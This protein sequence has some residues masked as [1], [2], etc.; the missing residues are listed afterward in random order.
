MNTT[1]PPARDLPPDAH[2]RIRGVVELTV[3]KAQRPA[4]LVPVVAGVAAVVLVAFFAWPRPG[5][6]GSSP[7][8]PPSRP[9]IDTTGPDVPG[10]SPQRRAEIEKKCSY[11][12]YPEQHHTTALYRLTKDAAGESVL[13][14]RD[15]GVATLCATDRLNEVMLGDTAPLNWLPGPLSFD[16]STVTAGGD[17]PRTSTEGSAFDPDGPPVPGRPGVETVAGRAAPAVA[18]VTYTST[19]G[20]TRDAV[21]ADGTF[22]VR[23]L[24]PSTWAAVASRGTLRAFD[25]DGVLLAAVSER[26][27]LNTCYVAPDGTVFPH[28]TTGKPPACKPAVPWH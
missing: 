28:G 25:A 5:H 13:L 16:A 3:T 22:V 27:R 2:A 19:D 14:Y 9:G 4:W 21:L 23:L 10:L 12:P 1:L 15:D 18:R 24:R 6:E 17:A 7:A 26:T 20:V 8:G 11:E